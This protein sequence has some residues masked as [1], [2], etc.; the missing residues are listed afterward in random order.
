M[1][2]QKKLNLILDKYIIGITPAR[3]VGG[4]AG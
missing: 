4:Q 2:Q 3:K 1:N